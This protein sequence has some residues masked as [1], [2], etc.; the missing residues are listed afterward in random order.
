MQQQQQQQRVSP[1]NGLHRI[2]AFATMV[3]KA[4]QAKTIIDA[5]ARDSPASS[6][7]VAR[8]SALFTEVHNY[9]LM[10]DSNPLAWLRDLWS[11]GYAYDRASGKILQRQ[12]LVT[13]QQY[14]SLNETAQIDAMLTWTR[15]CNELMLMIVSLVNWC[16]GEHDKLV[17]EQAR[18]HREEFERSVDN[19]FH[20]HMALQ[21]NLG[22]SA[23]QQHWPPMSQQFP[24]EQQRNAPRPPTAGWHMPQQWHGSPAGPSGLQLQ[25]A[26]YQ[27][28]NR[29]PTSATG[30]QGI[31]VNNPVPPPLHEHPGLTSA[32]REFLKNPGA[33]LAAPTY[34]PASGGSPANYLA[35]HTQGLQTKD[36]MNNPPTEKLHLGENGCL[37]MVVTKT[38][39]QSDWTKWMM[40][41]VVALTLINNGV[42]AEEAAFKQQLKPAHLKALVSITSAAEL[43]SYLDWAMIVLPST[44][45]ASFHEFDLS[46]RE[47]IKQQGTS[48][49][50]NL[51]MVS[52]K[53][54]THTH[55][56]PSTKVSSAKDKKHICKFFNSK[57]GCKFAAKECNNKHVCMKCKK[58]HPMHECDK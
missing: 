41:N 10:T 18:Q 37:Q 13:E 11:A 17:Q 26:P 27:Q 25:G 15:A 43:Q 42:S 7:I 2:N 48:G 12:H 30:V 49:L 44:T 56:S 4:N 55:L 5:L 47:E 33:A 38:P 28:F 16:S 19:A 8:I 23:D 46:L 51:N 3:E 50:Y 57:K 9:M 36:I 40:Q 29:V 20:Q 22:L 39:S 53:F 21:Q 34:T 14:L 24:Q 32:A 54:L 52:H 6:E 35:H 31:G 58:G 1:F 45:W